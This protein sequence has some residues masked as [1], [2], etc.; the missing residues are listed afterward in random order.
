MSVQSSAVVHDV[1]SSGTITPPA[2]PPPELEPAPPLAAAPADPEVSAGSSS[3]QE[4][5]ATASAAIAKSRVVARIRSL[6]V[7]PFARGIVPLL[8]P[9]RSRGLPAGLRGAFSAF[10]PWERRHR[11]YPRHPDAPCLAP[12][13]SVRDLRGVRQV[14][15]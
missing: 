6:P 15:A 14:A 4:S 8:W 2:P 10:V 11:R 5:G 9:R 13:R 3:E 12:R 7:V 1:Q